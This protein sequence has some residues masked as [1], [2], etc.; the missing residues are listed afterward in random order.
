MKRVFL[1]SLLSSLVLASCSDN[2]SADNEKSIDTSALNE[3]RLEGDFVRTLMTEPKLDFKSNAGV[4]VEVQDGFIKLEGGNPVS[5]SG[6]VTGGAYVF[7]S[8]EYETQ[9][10]EQTIAVTITAKGSLD[11]VMQTSYSTAQVG[12][13]GW[14]SFNLTENYEEYTF[15]YKIP[16]MIANQGDYLGVL[17]VNGPVYIQGVSIEIMDAQ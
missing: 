3:I 9:F 16:K 14:R 4:S 1:F 13:S 10:S 15:T 7:I 6:G 5:S 12:N 17:S 11:A 8:E 2:P